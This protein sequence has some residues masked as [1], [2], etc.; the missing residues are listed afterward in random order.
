MRHLLVLGCVAILVIP[1]WAQ[2]GGP[3]ATDEAALLQGEWIVVGM[4]SEGMKLKPETL[5]GMKWIITRRIITGTQP[6]V[7]GK[8]RYAVNPHNRP[9]DIDITSLDGKLKGK[10]T[11]GIYEV[12]GGQLRV[13][14]RS[15]GKVEERPKAFSDAEAEGSGCLLITFKKSKG[16]GG[17]SAVDRA[18]AAIAKQMKALKRLRDELEL[19][20]EGNEGVLTGV[21]TKIDA[22][23]STLGFTLRDTSIRAVDVPLASGFKV[24]VRS[25]GETIDDLKVGMRVSMRIITSEGQSAISV[26]RELPPKG[27]LG[28]ADSAAPASAKEKK[29]PRQPELESTLA[30]YAAVRKMLLAELEQ[31]RAEMVGVLTKIDVKKSIVSF[32]LRNTSIRVDVPLASGFKLDVRSKGETIDDLK[33]GMRVAMRII[34]SEGKSAISVFREPPPEPWREQA[35]MPR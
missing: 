33:V 28:G 34:T 26:V 30:K 11:L 24:D 35:V 29:V 25:K 21:L 17:A 22:D 10:T 7:T 18:A 32:T 4:E 3:P 12:K 20:R 16:Q 13:C 6:G 2:E 31:E 1:V 27:V 5:Q 14:F 19:E 8:M 9:R 15:A 23:K